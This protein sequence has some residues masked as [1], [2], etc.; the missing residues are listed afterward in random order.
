MSDVKHTAEGRWVYTSACPVF[1]GDTN[2]V[3][4][5]DGSIHAGWESSAEFETADGFYAWAKA[6][7]A[8]RNTLEAAAPEM[9]EALKM[10]LGKMDDWNQD[11]PIIR[12]VKS[13]IAKA[14]GEQ[15]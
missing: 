10:V 4:A 11:G 1:D 3:R 8:R 9:L 15:P 12:Q 7:C 6:E 14:S 2:K 5:Y 13:A